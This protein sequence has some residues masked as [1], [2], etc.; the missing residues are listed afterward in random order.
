M[1]TL[2]TIIAVLFGLASGTGAAVAQKDVDIEAPDGITLKG[3][4]RSPGGEGPAVLLLHQCNMDR[5]AWDGLAGD[6]AAAGFHVLTVD[7]RAFGDSG[8]ERFS[9]FRELGPVMADKW[10]ADVDAMYAYL[11]AQPGVDRTRV[12]VGGASCGVTQ[13]SSLAARRPEVRTM[14]V[15]SGIAGDEARSYIGQTPGLAIFGAASEGDTGAANGIKAILAASRNSASTLEMYDGTD[16][17]VPMFD[18]RAELQPMVVSWFR[19]R[20]LAGR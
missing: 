11:L 16:H 20:L 7:F 18:R 19:A 9:S 2:V 3:T 10:P 14:M 6:L 1:K 15:L 4:Y 12:A 8:G 5:H 13:A 17:G